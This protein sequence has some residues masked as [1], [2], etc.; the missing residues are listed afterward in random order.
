MAD[1]LARE[2]RLLFAFT[3]V[4]RTIGGAAL[5]GGPPRVWLVCYSPLQ[6]LVPDGNLWRNPARGNWEHLPDAGS[7]ASCLSRN[8]GGHQRSGTPRNGPRV[9]GP[10]PGVDH[11]PA[12]VVLRGMWHKYTPKGAFVDDQ[13]WALRPGSRASRL[14][15]SITQT[16]PEFPPWH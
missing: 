14:L 6:N 16:P 4:M 13:G 10:I 12:Y 7:V 8:D 2:H 9:V 3:R 1:A 15:T 5:F 11:L